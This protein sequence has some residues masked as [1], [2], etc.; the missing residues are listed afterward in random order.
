MAAPILATRA[1][2]LRTHL[3][4]ETFQQIQLLSPDIGIV[5]CMRRVPRGKKAETQID[6]FDEADIHVELK[7]NE[8][9]GFLKGFELAFKRSGIGAS[10][11]TL[12]AASR[13]SRLLLEN[14]IQEDSFQEMFDLAK[15]A[16]NAFND[17]KPPDATLLKT[18]FLYCRNEGY[19]VIEEWLQNLNP[20]MREKIV[21]IVSAPLLKMKRSA[22]DQSLAVESLASYL[23][24][25]TDI[26]FT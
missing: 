19:P 16:L 8:Y 26:R 2:V 10:Y 20:S 21:S 12:A 14:P 9:S 7:E 1:I 24:S 13:L 23:R 22:Q 17:G 5:R 15:K 11:E 3:S 4:G 25:H 6:L 18:V